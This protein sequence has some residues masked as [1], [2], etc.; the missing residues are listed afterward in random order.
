MGEDWFDGLTGLASVSSDERVVYGYGG[1]ELHKRVTDSAFMYAKYYSEYLGY[2]RHMEAFRI[3]HNSV[4]ERFFRET[5]LAIRECSD[6]NKF[7]FPVPETE[8]D[9]LAM[10]FDYFHNEPNR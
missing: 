10:V 5:V 7:A 3:V 1:L 4:R 2:K 6:G 9:C 8:G